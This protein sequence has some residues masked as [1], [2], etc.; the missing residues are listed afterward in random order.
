M[1]SGRQ[2]AASRQAVLSLQRMRTGAGGR[3]ANDAL[4]EEYANSMRGS[5][6]SF[7]RMRL[8]GS[9]GQRKPYCIHMEREGTSVTETPTKSAGCHAFCY[10]TDLELAP[11]GLLVE[12]VLQTLEKYSDL[13]AHIHVLVCTCTSRFRGNEHE[14]QIDTLVLKCS[15]DGD[16]FHQ[17]N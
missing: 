17:R 6:R 9:S 2:E 5:Q 15:S 12:D 4:K 8:C 16:P 11:L 3:E 7:R 1:R 13:N 14:V 10:M